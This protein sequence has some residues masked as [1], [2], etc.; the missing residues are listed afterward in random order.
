MSKKVPETGQLAH[1][2]G[3]LGSVVPTQVG[4]LRTQWSWSR[5]TAYSS[6]EVEQVSIRPSNRQVRALGST[7][8]QA[9][10]VFMGYLA[11]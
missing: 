11:K 4:L 10:Q 9:R 8:V 2:E 6:G 3:S 7:S 5:V 1:L